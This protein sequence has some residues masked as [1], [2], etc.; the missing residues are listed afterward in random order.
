MASLSIANFCIQHFYTFFPQSIAQSIAVL[1]LVLVT[2]LL[3]GYTTVQLLR[4]D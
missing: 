1:L 3:R 2:T 4:V